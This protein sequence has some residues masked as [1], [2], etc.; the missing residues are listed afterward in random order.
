MRTPL[1]DRIFNT[2]RF[3]RQVV[4]NPNS[5]AHR[6][7][8]RNG[9][10]IEEDIGS[11]RDFYKWVLTKLGPPPAPDSRIIRKDQSRGFLRKNL[12]WGT[13]REQGNRL[14]SANRIRFRGETRCLKQWAEE[15]GIPVDTVYGRYYKGITNPRE[16]FRE[17]V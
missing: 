12:E 13:H 4:Y 1:E 2:H 17:R 10:P 16:L 8:T 6:T 11:F 7:W 14:L 5:P 15:L 3:I 9:L